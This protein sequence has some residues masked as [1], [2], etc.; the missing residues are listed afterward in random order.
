M[1]QFTKNDIRDYLKRITDEQVN[2][3]IHNIAINII[4]YQIFV[5]GMITMTI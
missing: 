2:E 1:I 4:S 5:L 3:L